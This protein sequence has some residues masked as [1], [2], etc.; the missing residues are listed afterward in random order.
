MLLMYHAACEDVNGE[1][2]PIHRKHAIL[3][4]IPFLLV[5]L[6]TPIYT[7]SSTSWREHAWRI[8]HPGAQ[9]R[10]GCAPLHL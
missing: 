9:K 6:T 2:T 7:H 8:R 4:I 10:I 3:G 5:Q 1:T